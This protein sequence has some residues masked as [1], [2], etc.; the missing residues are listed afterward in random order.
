MV[1]MFWYTRIYYGVYIW[2]DSINFSGVW[3]FPK[4]ERLPIYAVYFL[5]YIDHV[6]SKMCD[7]IIS[8]GRRDNLHTQTGSLLWEYVNLPG[9]LHL[10]HPSQRSA[11]LVTSAFWTLAP[12]DSACVWCTLRDVLPGRLPRSRVRGTGGWVSGS[13]SVAASSYNHWGLQTPGRIECQDLIKRPIRVRCWPHRT[14]T[15][16]MLAST[17][18]FTGIYFLI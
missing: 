12:P 18:M 9:T 8:S 11:V 7:Q 10:L 3:S 6:Y 16:P 2:V 5:S 13:R 17:H 1:I 15:G 4:G 14:S